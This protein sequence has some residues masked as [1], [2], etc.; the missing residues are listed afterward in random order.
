MCSMAFV[1]KTHLQNNQTQMWPQFGGSCCPN[2]RH[3]TLCFAILLKF[4]RMASLNTIRQLRRN[5]KYFQRAGN[6]V[7]SYRSHR[8]VSGR[9]G[10]SLVIWGIHSDNYMGFITFSS[11]RYIPLYT[12]PFWTI[13]FIL[14]VARP[15]Q[16]CLSVIARDTNAASL[17]FFAANKN[18]L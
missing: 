9:R 6:Y 5:L 10:A 1:A 8:D 12:F 11:Q 4:L 14:G 17:M 3:P 2:F 15:H 16:D 7:A 18:S 13:Q